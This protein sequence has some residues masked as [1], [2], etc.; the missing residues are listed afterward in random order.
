[1]IVQDVEVYSPRRDDYVVVEA[2]ID[3]GASVCV[4]AQHVAEE[5]GIA[6]K[7]EF[8]H[9]WQV[10]DPLVLHQ[11][12]VTIHY[13]RRLYQARATV[14]DIPEPYRRPIQSGEECTRPSSPHPLTER[15]I[16]GESFLNQLPVEERRLVLLSG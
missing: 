14:V 10:R 15:M 1:M 13:E 7:T 3:T 16:V 9:L 4:L 5:L 8:S 2:I 12:T 11:A 6:V